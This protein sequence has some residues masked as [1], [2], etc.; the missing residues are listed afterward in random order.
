MKTAKLNLIAAAALLLG[1]AGGAFAG[2]TTGTIAV[3]ATVVAS[4]TVATT[5]LNFGTSINVLSGAPING[6]ATVTTTCSNEAPYTIKLNAGTTSGA[7]VTAR[8]MAG[9]TGGTDTLN[10]SLSAVSNGGSNWGNDASTDVDDTGNG[11]AQ[12]HT[13]YGQIP[14]G[15]NTVSVGA[16]TDTIT[17][18]VDF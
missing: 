18:T 6:T 15:Q 10:Y 8:K 9:G 12:A 1:S 17:A 3:S 4:C 2:S 16:Y 13:V 14:S 11:T 5:P 7:T